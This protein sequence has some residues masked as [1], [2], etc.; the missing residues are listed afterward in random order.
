MD[1]K[2]VFK[3]I[4]DHAVVKIDRIVEHSTLMQCIARHGIFDRTEI[5]LLEGSRNK[6]QRRYILNDED[7]PRLQ[8][9][10]KVSLMWLRKLYVDETRDGMLCIEIEFR[11]PRIEF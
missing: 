2:E 7:M 10:A 6:F 5:K 4:I 11:Q 1:N 3:H 9:E 8:R